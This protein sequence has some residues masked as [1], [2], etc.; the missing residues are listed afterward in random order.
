MKLTAQ[1]LLTLLL[2]ILLSIGFGLG[3]DAIATAIEKK[4]HPRP[5]SIAALISANSKEFGVPE[6]IIWATVK[7]ESDFA[8]NAVSSTG[9]IGLM[10]ISPVRSAMICKDLLQTAPL[11]AG[12]LYDPATNLRLGTAYLSWLYQRY[13]VWE[14]VYVAYF[15]GTETVDAWLKDPSYVT[16]QGVLTDLP[17]QDSAS[18][19]KKMKKSV[20]LYGKLYYES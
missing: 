13:G 1:R 16:P 2:L 4:N 10:Q 3:F 8:S 14:N 19:L 5:Q 20:S 7:H 12:M 11:D 17:D 18:Y 6:A 15:A 9:E